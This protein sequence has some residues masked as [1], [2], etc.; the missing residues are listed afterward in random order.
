MKAKE[1]RAGDECFSDIL[2]FEKERLEAL[3]KKADGEEWENETTIHLIYEYKNRIEGMELA[4]RL[5]SLNEPNQGQ[6]E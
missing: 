6:G 5:L 4:K 2:N 1:R 3:R